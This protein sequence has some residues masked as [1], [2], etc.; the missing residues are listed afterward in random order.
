MRKNINKEML[1]VLLNQIYLCCVSHTH[2]FIQNM[3]NDSWIFNKKNNDRD[4]SVGS[5]YKASDY[6]FRI[7]VLFV[8]L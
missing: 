8:L 1:K 7:F 5:Y 2:Q 6:G 3:K 4:H